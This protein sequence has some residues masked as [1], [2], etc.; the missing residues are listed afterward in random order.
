MLHLSAEYYIGRADPQ[1][2]EVVAIHKIA[3][4]DNERVETGMRSESNVVDAIDRYEILRE[5][6]VEMVPILELYRMTSHSTAAFVASSLASVRKACGRPAFTCVLGVT[7][8]VSRRRCTSFL[9][10]VD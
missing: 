10:D 5:P 2:V 3:S 9:D 8:L 6:S 1:C 7:I 4:A